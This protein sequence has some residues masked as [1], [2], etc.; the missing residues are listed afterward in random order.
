MTLFRKFFITLIFIIIPA[1]L[2]AN[3]SLKEK[4]KYAD[5]LYNNAYYKEAVRE[6][7]YLHYKSENKP[8][9]DYYL[10]RIARCYLED[11]QFQKAEIK[12]R[13]LS[14]SDTNPYY[15]TGNLYINYVRSIFFQ[16]KFHEAAFEAENSPVYETTPKL[17]ELAGWSYIN[18]NNWHQAAGIFT[19]LSKDN[20]ER[21][22]KMAELLNN[23]PD[24][25]QKNPLAAAIMSAFIPGAGHAYCGNWA[26]AVGAFT[27]NLVF[28]GLTAYSIVKKEWV[29]AAVFGFM[30]TGWYSGNIVSAYQEANLM[31]R[32]VENDFKVRLSAQFPVEFTIK[33]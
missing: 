8:Q 24:F 32:K 21:Y 5:Y 18:R 2:M 17:R 29:Y 16:K 26:T 28:G 31:N 14:E 12:F 13:K 15:A 27:T 11:G 30:E 4:E 22:I 25:R 23:P 19:N 3:E 20:N 33:K 10:Y 9:K 1:F 6:N 7:L